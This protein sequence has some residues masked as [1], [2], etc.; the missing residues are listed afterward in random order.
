MIGEIMVAG[1]KGFQ[2]KPFA[3]VDRPVS[4]RGKYGR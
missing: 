4:R 2:L 3:R 1:E